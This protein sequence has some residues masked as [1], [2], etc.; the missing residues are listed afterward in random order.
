M[1]DEVTVAGLDGDV[2]ILTDR[3]GVPHVYARSPRDAYLAQGF[4]AAR[5]RL[6]QIDLWRRRGLGRLAEV[7]GPTAVEADRARRLFLYRGDMDREWSSYPSA[8]N[9]GGSR[10]GSSTVRST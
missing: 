2:E 4:Q 5:D 1:P 3:W 6:F 7:L 9:S 8:A 10:A